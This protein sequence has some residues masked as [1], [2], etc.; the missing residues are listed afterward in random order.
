MSD[1][2]LAYR[3][4]AIEGASPLGLMIAL[5]DTLVGDFRRAAS[6][7]RKDD[8]EARCRDLNH[9]ALVLGRLESWIDM[10]NGGEPSRNLSRFYTHLRA[11]MLEAS[12]TKSA[13]V[14]DT[15]IETILNVRSAWQQLDIAPAPVMATHAGVPLTQINTTYSGSM[16]MS[17]RIPLSLSA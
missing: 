5:L 6:A 13:A 2:E 14:L 4:T 10:K 15:Q 11:K 3:R 16:E 9:A 7:I 12:A 8:I 17:E 1:M